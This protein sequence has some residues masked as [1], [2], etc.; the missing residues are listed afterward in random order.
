MDI[1]R[2]TRVLST[3][4]PEEVAEAFLGMAKRF[5]QT[6][7]DLMREILWEEVIA[8]AHRADDPSCD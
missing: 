1:V 6:P 4:V 8:E 2:N 3:K 7:S 5:G